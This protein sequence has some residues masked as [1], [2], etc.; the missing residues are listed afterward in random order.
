MPP[1]D[2]DP[3]APTPDGKKPSLGK[4]FLDRVK[5]P[6][7]TK[8]SSA[9]STPATRSME[10][11]TASSAADEKPSLSKRLLTPFKGS[12]FIRNSSA[13]SAQSVEN[14]AAP[15]ASIAQLATNVLGKPPHTLLVIARRQTPGL[16]TARAVPGASASAQLV[17]ATGTTSAMNVDQGSPATPAAAGPTSAMSIDQ[18]GSVTPAGTYA[19][20]ITFAH[21]ALVGYTA[22]APTSSINVN[23]HS[24]PAAV[25]SSVVSQNAPAMNP[26]SMINVDQSTLPGP[27]VPQ[28]QSKFKGGV[29]VALDGCLTALRVAKEA[30][31]WNPFLRATLGGVMAA[32]DL[33]KTVSG[34]SEDM[35]GIVV[36]IQGLLPIL[37]T[38]AK[39]L[40]GCKDDFGKGNNLMTFA[41]T[42]QAELEKIQ[43]MQ[44]HGLLKRV[45][46]GPKDA[47]T[48][49][50]VYKN[51]S[52]SLEQFK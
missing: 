38:S 5:G 12:K 27:N 19:P 24:P 31:D 51:I 48:L 7:S 14:L 46:Q 29:T 21:R 30:S 42:M 45:L 20:L 35:K 3:I 28:A 26:V 6:K 1:A 41:I 15:G 49:L 10:I 18:H 37:E 17:T 2:N 47:T 36:R 40:E 32:I 50:G 44:S 39:R 8:S 34:N 23:Q 43:E 9:L 11:R 4:R 25:P 22:A 13:P 33:A 16:V 52:E